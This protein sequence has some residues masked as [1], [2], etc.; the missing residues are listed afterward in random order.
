MAQRKRFN[1]I[2]AED[3][4]PS[5]PSESPLPIIMAHKDLVDRLFKDR[6]FNPISQ[7][8]KYRTFV[9]D[10]IELGLTIDATKEI[11]NCYNVIAVVPGTDLDLSDEYI[12]V[13]AHLDHLGREGD[14]IYYGANDD[15]SG[16]VLILEVAEA[17]AQNPLRHP[18]MFVLYTAE[19]AGHIGSL[20]FLAH[21]PVPMAEI[22][23]NI[24]LE[25]IGA[26]TRNI[27]GIWGIG[28]TSQKEPLFAARKKVEG[29]DLQFDT[30]DSQI[31]TIKGTDTMSF[32]LKEVPAIILGSGGFPEHHTSK[33]TV[34][35][36]DYD[37]LYK[38]TLLVHAYIT[39][40]GNRY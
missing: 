1:L 16:C 36:I 13:G 12:T 37:H 19:E 20:H 34:D 22:L 40:L 38:A 21:P 10:D 23:L 27:S 25:Q 35:L 7:Q 32:Y 2:A 8:G 28:P 17:V 9:M 39:E 24:N 31:P 3:Y 5:V 33:D 18:V 14:V 30:T 11:F 15:V 6:D 29:I 26:R 4:G